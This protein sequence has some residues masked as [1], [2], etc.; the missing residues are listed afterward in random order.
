MYCTRYK[1]INQRT[2][3]H[4]PVFREGVKK[5]VLKGEFTNF[6]I[7]ILNEAPR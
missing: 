2:N 6:D 3:Y 7:V 1:S 4:E 5:L